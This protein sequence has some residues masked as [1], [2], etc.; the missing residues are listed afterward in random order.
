[1]ESKDISKAAG[2]YFDDPRLQMTA[3]G[4]LFVRSVAFISYAFVSAFTAT[5]LLSDVPGLRWAGVLCAIF[6]LDRIF[7]IDQG[8]RP[9]SRISFSG[10]ENLWA[11]LSP[12]SSKV[13]EKAFE[14]SRI[15]GSSF[16]IE[17]ILQL[18]EIDEIKEGLSR[19]DLDKEEFRQKAREFIGGGQRISRSN[20][21]EKVSEL[22]KYSLGEA[23]AAHHRFIEPSDI[24]C[25]FF[26]V[27]EEN[28]A[29]VMNVFEIGQ[30]DLRK[31][32]VFSH[33][34][35]KLFPWWK[36]NSSLGEIRFV[37]GGHK[38]MNRA[39]T[40]RPTPTLDRFSSDLTDMAR[41]GAVGFIV[42]HEE[43][44]KHMVSTL[45][46]PINPN[47]LLVGREGIGKETLVMHLALNITEDKVPKDLMDKRVVALEINSLVSG[48]TGDELAKRIDTITQE[49]AIAGNIILFVPD[50]HNLVKTTGA[51][52][53]SAADAIIPVIRNNAFPVIGATYPRE[54]AEFVE[55]RSDFLGVFDVINVSEI[56]PDEAEELLV[57]ESA[58]LERKFKV[59]ISFSAIK[60]AV[61]VGKKYLHAKP[62]PSSAEE[63]L[64]EAVAQVHEQGEKKVGS[65]DVTR[66]AEAKVNV[67][68]H[69][70]GEQEAQT[71]LNLEAIIHERLID[72]EEAV[73]AVS[74]ALRE[75]RSG[76]TRPGGPIASFLFVGPTGVGKTELAKNLARIHFGSEEAMIRFDMTEFQDKQSFYRFIG[77]A[78]HQVSG[79]L[80]EAVLKKP[81]SLILL[82]EFEKAFPDILNL[83]LQV[84]DDGRLTDAFGQMV[85]FT[86]TIIIAT[87]NAHSELVIE[88]LRGGKSAA[89]VSETLKKRL[90]DVFKPELINRFSKVVVFKSLSPQ[91]MLKITQLN[92]KD[93]AKLTLQQGIALE[94]DEAAA[95]KVSALGYDPAFGARPL[96]Q[97]ISEKLRAPLSEMILRKEI[98]RGSRV[99]LKLEGEDLKFVKL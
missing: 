59:L 78:D 17:L 80:T 16:H 14:K 54:Y 38:I 60:Q 35:K 24:F 75:Y 79:M 44:Y 73:K 97:I 95:E 70:V 67:P 55:P 49:I 33:A 66:I 20:L 2:I 53:L 26:E 76:L 23:L 57:Y 87:S 36:K 85:D 27:N 83:F 61:L 39:W 51:G 28:S 46:R 89:E 48:A 3:F 10:R 93:L 99:H 40:S 15:S 25:A 56:T 50:M 30:D 11:Y 81:Y 21:L 91:D 96:R 42:G 71:L 4:R 6:L 98:V 9:L 77:S 13:I 32:L 45:S 5:S 8:R 29:R 58:M 74:Q 19:L 34:K 84:L 86:N 12:L 88:A 37:K 52:Y 43:D 31:A 62:L 72:Q 90:V 92:L 82:D 47:V 41:K 94:W 1:M 69:E 68:I 18:L 65:E 22:T 63:V 64:K 7:H